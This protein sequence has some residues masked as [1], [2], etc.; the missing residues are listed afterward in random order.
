M[1]QG[2]VQA[3]CLVTELPEIKID[4]LRVKCSLIHLRRKVLKY[5]SS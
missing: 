5:P 2:E 1:A 4:I 3:L